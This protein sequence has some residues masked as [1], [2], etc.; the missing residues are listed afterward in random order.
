MTMPNFFIVGAPKAGTDLL[1]Y[2]LDQH[3]QIYMSPLKEPN[4]FSA[5]VRSDN[6]HPSLQP[7]IENSADTMR[8]Y[9]ESKPLPKRF[10]GMVTSH[11]DYEKLFAQVR[12]QRAIGEGSVCYLWSST[13]AATIANA[14]S[15]A[16]IIMVLMDPAERAF[17]QYLKSLAD[18]NVS[19]SF[20]CHL[21]LAFEDKTYAPLQIRLLNPFLS[22]GEY[23]MQVQRYLKHFA[24]EQLFVSVYEDVQKDYPSWWRRVLDFLEVDSDFVPNGVDVP[25]TPHFT[26]RPVP[27]MLPQ[28]RA[29]LVKFYRDDI[30]QLQ[31]LIRLD[32]R[33]WLV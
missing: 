6:F 21:D 19:H 12:S 29:R 10:G 26:N 18:G 32:L 24:R 7:Y 2:Q 28:E 8:E 27:N 30:L 25:S 31:D 5:E 22:F 14:V 15:N 23:S 16:K 20:S 4:F 9:L 11:S 1:F 33:H 3:P 17:H 13:A